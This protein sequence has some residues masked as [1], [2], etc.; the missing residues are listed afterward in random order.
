MTAPIEKLSAMRIGC[1]NLVWAKL[2]KDDG[3][4]LTYE[5]PVALPGLMSIGI[6]PNTESA[7]AFYDDGPAE[8]ATTLGAIDVTIKKSALGTKEA[9]TLLGHSMDENGMVV[10]GANDKA[11][12]GALGFRTMKSD[13]TYKYCWLL[14]GVFVDG[15]EE[16]E[17]KGDSINFQSDEL[18]GKF[19]KV[20]K[21]FTFTDTITGEE[22]ETQPWRVM[23]DSGSE[24]A[25]TELVKNWF[26]KVVTPGE[27]E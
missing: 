12:E 4:T 11:P 7:T 5:T 6:N 3:V 22:K 13:G 8:S 9:A 25:S 19:A 10:Y 26:T 17:T 24:D 14:K 18:V 1:D 23:I 2:T 15:E 27:A 21:K 20:N 16:N